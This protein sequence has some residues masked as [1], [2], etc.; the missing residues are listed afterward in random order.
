MLHHTPFPTANALTVNTNW[1]VIAPRWLVR[2]LQ[3]IAYLNN[4][5]IV[6]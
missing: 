5:I 3:Y 2:Q 1:N 6:S 4:F